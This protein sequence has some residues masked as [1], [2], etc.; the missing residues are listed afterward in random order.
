MEFDI[1][2]QNLAMIY[3]LIG[4]SLSQKKLMWVIYGNLYYQMFTN[5]KVFIYDTAIV[6]L[7]RFHC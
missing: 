1:K 6:N 2:V 5:N 7:G 4:Q 3:Y